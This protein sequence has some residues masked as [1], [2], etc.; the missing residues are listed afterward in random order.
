M[1]LSRF[2]F[3]GLLLLAGMGVVPTD[4]LART[5]GEDGD[6][7]RRCITQGEYFTIRSYLNTSKA[8]TCQIDQGAPTSIGPNSYT[9]GKSLY[10]LDYKLPATFQNQSDNK[11]ANDLQILKIEAGIPNWRDVLKKHKIYP[12]WTPYIISSAWAERIGFQTYPSRYVALGIDPSSRIS[13]AVPVSFKQ[14]TGIG[15]AT[16]WYVENWTGHSGSTY[17][18]ARI[19]VAYTC[20]QFDYNAKVCIFGKDTRFSGFA[21]AVPA[22]SGGAT[23]LILQHA[24]PATPQAQR[25]QQFNLSPQRTHIPPVDMGVLFGTPEQPGMN[26]F[27]FCANNENSCGVSF[28]KNVTDAKKG[29]Y[30]SLELRRSGKIKKTLRVGDVNT[31]FKAVYPETRPE[32]LF[33]IS[34]FNANIYRGNAPVKRTRKVTKRNDLF[35]GKDAALMTNYP[36]SIAMLKTWTQ[37]H[38]KGFDY[39]NPFPMMEFDNDGRVTL[40]RYYDNGNN[41]GQPLALCIQGPE[42]ILDVCKT[43]S[44]PTKFDLRFVRGQYMIAPFN[45]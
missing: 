42:D 21:L 11:W 22:Y 10:C 40:S 16:L 31:P 45:Q 28:L 18:P 37:Q 12:K 34:E 30:F 7:A 29:T 9:Q 23:P 33:T 17:Q 3:S 27:G 1:R 24:V 4:G 32:E 14:A 41:G 26:T 38:F 39:E 8:T 25:A 13:N 2:I 36:P 35:G 5:C 19:T 20:Q 15:P 6:S 43:G 44:N